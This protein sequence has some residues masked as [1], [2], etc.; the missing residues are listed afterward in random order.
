MLIIMKESFDEV[1]GKVTDFLKNETKT[2]TVIG[3]TFELGEFKCVPVIRVGMGFG[4]GGG[5][6]EG[7][8]PS[9]GHGKGG[10]SGTG[11][12]MG[13]EPMGFLVTRGDQISFIPTRSSKGLTAAFEKVPELLEKY[14]EKKETAQAN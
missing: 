7:D 3:Q 8:A 10:G 6:G 4:F 2:E 5:E 12:G 9:K 11:A 14:F 13:V 1:L